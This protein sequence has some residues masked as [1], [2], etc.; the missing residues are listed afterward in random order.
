MCQFASGFLKPAGPMTVKVS[1]LHSHSGTSEKLGLAAD[2]NTPNA[3]REFHYLPDGVIECRVLPIDEYSA[4]ECEAKLLKR[5]P[6]FVDFFSW[7]VAEGAVFD[8]ALDLS[9]LTSAEGLVLPE[10]INYLHLSESI[11]R[12]LP[13][14]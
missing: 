11:R 8:S 9:G 2:S 3:W 1:D 6:R 5:W 10:G 14:R 13:P 12:S 7:C 4:S